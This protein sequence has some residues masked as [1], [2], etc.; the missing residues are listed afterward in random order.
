MGATKMGTGGL[1]STNKPD[2]LSFL[3]AV[4]VIVVIAVGWQFAVW[5]VPERAVVTLFPGGTVLPVT[6]IR[7]GVLP[8]REHDAPAAVPPLLVARSMDSITQRSSSRLP[9]AAH[10]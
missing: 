9:P 6:E 8:A 7:V 1:H 4:A 10:R 3:L 2:A 5:G